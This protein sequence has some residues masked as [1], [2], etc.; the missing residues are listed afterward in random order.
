MT[1]EA[2]ESEYK[3]KLA[4]WVLAV[5]L[6]AK[7]VEG[8][9]EISKRPIYDN[10]P[11]RQAAI[12]VDNNTFGGSS[13]MVSAKYTAAIKEE[14]KAITRQRSQEIENGKEEANE[15]GKK[16]GA[17]M[18]AGLLGGTALSSWRSRKENNKNGER[19]L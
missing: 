3:E 14:E 18:M 5:A 2:H 7:G 6:A 19:Q 13:S 15:T 12:N 8:A 1:Q 11:A 16:A 17:L 10:S 4:K 9:E